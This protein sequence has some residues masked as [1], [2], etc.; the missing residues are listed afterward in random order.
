VVEPKEPAVE[1]KEP[2]VE[3]KEVAAVE[4]IIKKKR[5]TKAKTVPSTEI[6]VE[7]ETETKVE[8]VTVDKKKRTKKINIATTLNQDDVIIPHHEL[9]LLDSFVQEKHSD[10]RDI[11]GESATLNEEDCETE[12]TEV[13]VDDVLFYKDLHNNWFDLHLNPIIKPI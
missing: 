13:F 3:Q 2:A 12:L 5:A 1:Q 6:Y 4:P 11:S 10:S 7:A 9:S 8:T